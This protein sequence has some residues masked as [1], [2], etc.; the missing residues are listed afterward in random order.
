M[1]AMLTS[2]DNM[3][4]YA[5]PPFALMGQVLAKLRRSRGARLILIAP[6]WPRQAW[7][8]HLFH[9]AIAVPRRLPLFP[10]LLSQPSAP[11]GFQGL[12]ALALTAW[13]LG[14]GNL[15]RRAFREKLPGEL[16]E[17]CDPLRGGCPC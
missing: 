15:E 2:W 12:G 1:D 8:P 17:M 6:F 4:A 9:L 11:E 16:L 13:L 7:F 5:Y 10:G 14:S 3:L